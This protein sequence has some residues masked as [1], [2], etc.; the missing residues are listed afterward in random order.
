[1]VKAWRILSDDETRRAYDRNLAA[2]TFAEDVVRGFAETT[3]GASPRVGRMI[4]RIYS[5]LMR[6]TWAAAG[7]MGRGGIEEAARAGER[8]QKA[9]ER[10]RGVDRMAVLNKSLEC[11]RR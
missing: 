3:D 7:G 11:E 5:P 2:G 8:A 10:A 6:R 9:Y 4:D 1:M